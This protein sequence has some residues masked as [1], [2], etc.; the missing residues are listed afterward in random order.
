MKARTLAG[1]ALVVVGGACESHPY[2]HVSG[3]PT[4]LGESEQG[5]SGSLAVADPGPGGILV[6]A[7]GEVLALGG[8]P[9]PPV[10]PGDTAFVDGW[11]MQFDRLLVTVDHVVLS[12]GPD[13]A[14]TDQSQTGPVV[15]RQD[16]PWAIDLH[17]GG[18]LQGKGGN[19][20]EAVAFT[21]FTGQN[22]NGGAAF[23]TTQRYAFGF[24]VVA[25]SASAINVNLTADDASDYA[26][27]VANGYTVL[28]VGTAT[29]QGVGCT[30]PGSTYDFTK[31]P[32]VVHFRLGFQSPTTYVN[33]QNPDNDPA[34]PF[35]GEEHERGVQVLSNRSIVS[36]VTIHTDHPFWEST[37]HDTPAHFDPLA[38][39][40]VGADA[41]IPLATLAD[42][43]GVDFLGFHDSDGTPL[44]WR[45]CL[46]SYTAQSGTMSFDPHGVPVNPGADPSQALR[47]YRDFMAYDQS[48]QGH[49]NAD[50]LCYVKRNYPSPP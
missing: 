20:E 25:A 28:Y 15:A 45:S 3:H 1:L 44:P 27:M 16:G 35:P 17:L 46:A 33:C 19:G 8:Y 48:T 4:V 18:P 6:S 47:D 7:S 49:L 31:L 26:D 13:I 10:N 24:D 41:G 11:A 9:F 32:P 29:F 22:R 2:D 37:V 40:H 42:Q 36:Q 30:G 38:A 14:P 23:D 50:G 43:V 39:R 5:D 21:S 12:A 34:A